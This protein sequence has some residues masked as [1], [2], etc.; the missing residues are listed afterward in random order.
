MEF[1]CSTQLNNRPKLERRL[2]IKFTRENVET[3]RLTLMK[4]RGA[5]G[6]GTGGLGELIEGEI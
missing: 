5:H 6:R 3:S 4:T 1:L 2:R